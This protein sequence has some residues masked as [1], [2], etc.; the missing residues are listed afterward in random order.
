MP[1]VLQQMLIRDEGSKRN[2]AGDH[3]PYR[4]SAGKL[5]LGYGRN[6]EE[7]GI[8]EQEALLLLNNDIQLCIGELIRSI[9]AYNRI[10]DA[11]QA[12]LVNMCFN[13]G[14]GRLLGFKK[15]LLALEAGDFRRAADEMLDS[16]WAAQVGRRAQRLA[17]Q[18]RMGVWPQ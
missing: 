8:T 18:M 4:C 9:P 13:V 6:I 12:V 5:T 16:Q 10:N 15:M 7:R 14:I 2:A 17:L 11:R 1:T 3:L